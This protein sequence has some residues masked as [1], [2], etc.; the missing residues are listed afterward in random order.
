MIDCVGMDRGE[1][2]EVSGDAYVNCDFEVDV[3][4]C[5]DGRGERNC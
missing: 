1:V 4:R 5:V 2:L 3:A